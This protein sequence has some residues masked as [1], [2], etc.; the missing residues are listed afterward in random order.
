MPQTPLTK[1]QQREAKVRRLINRAKSDDGILKKEMYEAIGVSEAT[2][3]HRQ[4]TP[5]MFT[6][7]EL[8]KLCDFLNVPDEKRLELLK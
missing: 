8:W 4:E 7:A 1:T 2:F 6:L 3:H 5:G